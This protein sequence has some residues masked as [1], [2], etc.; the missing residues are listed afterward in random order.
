MRSPKK[1]RCLLRTEDPFV[2]H[3]E[4][5]SKGRGALDVGFVQTGWESF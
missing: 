3:V 1:I 5:L 4:N 2:M